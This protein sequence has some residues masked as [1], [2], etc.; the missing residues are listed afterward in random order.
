MS[1]HSISESSRSGSNRSGSSTADVGVNG[2]RHPFS[3]ALYAQ[4][5]DGHIIVTL[6]ERQGVFH[7]NG[8]WISGE[9]READ[10]QLCGWVGGPIVGNHRVTPSEH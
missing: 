10:P 8:R 3:G 7:T 9:L 6:G 1:T 4:D 5:G 2:L